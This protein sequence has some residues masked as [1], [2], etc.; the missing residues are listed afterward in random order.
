MVWSH[1]S[2]S[3]I[4]FSRKAD[5]YKKLGLLVAAEISAAQRNK[6]DHLINCIVNKN[7]ISAEHASFESQLVQEIRAEK[8]ELF[9]SIL[10]EPDN[11]WI[12]SLKLVVELYNKCIDQ[13]QDILSEFQK[14]REIAKLRG[15]KFYSV[16]DEIGKS[17]KEGKA[18][19]IRHLYN[20][21][22]VINIVGAE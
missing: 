2:E 13:S 20:L 19:S 1:S 17:L 4:I 10:V 3:P 5:F 22:N 21:N 8:P 16:Y 9:D 12:A 11:Q 15:A 7:D 18:P 6:I 14:Q